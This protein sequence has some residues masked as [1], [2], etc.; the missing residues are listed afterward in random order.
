LSHTKQS[1]QC[2]ITVSRP[3]NTQIGIR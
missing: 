2:A 1:L 3:F